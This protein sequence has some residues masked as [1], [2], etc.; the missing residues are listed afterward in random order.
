MVEKKD[1]DY[2][3]EW[4]R[5]W[6]NCLPITTCVHVTRAVEG[7]AR[8]NFPY[9]GG[10][11]VRGAGSIVQGKNKPILYERARQKQRDGIY[12]CVL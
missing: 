6:V 12:F 11:P 9:G 5:P 7:W 2:D 8:G 1:G 3:G 10:L 4:R